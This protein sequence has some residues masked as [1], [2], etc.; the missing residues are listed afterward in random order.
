MQKTE[1]IEKL[2]NKEL[3]ETLTDIYGDTGRIDYQEARYI[4]ALEKFEMLYGDG[5]LSI[6]SAPGRTEIIGNHTDHQ[7]GKVIAA[8]VSM[9][10]IAIVKKSEDI[11]EG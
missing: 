1:I 9:D 7:H 6:Y 10:A 8:A 11:I 4:A 2:K 5:D 3:T